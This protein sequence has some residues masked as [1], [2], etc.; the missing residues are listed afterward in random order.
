MPIVV[1]MQENAGSR[2]QFLVSL[3]RGQ[4]IDDRGNGGAGAIRLRPPARGAVLGEWQASDLRAKLGVAQPDATG[5]EM[6]VKPHRLLPQGE[7]ATATLTAAGADHSPG[8][9][10]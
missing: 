4:R 8:A 6:Y 3:L 5:R 7:R 1:F 9:S 10:R 2:R